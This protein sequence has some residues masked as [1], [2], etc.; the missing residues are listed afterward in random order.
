M[1][2]TVKLTQWGNSVGVRLP[3]TMLQSLGLETGQQMEIEARDGE[4][5]LRPRQRPALDALLAQ[6]DFTQAADTEDSE[7]FDD[8]PTG[9]EYI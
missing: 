2:T 8:A 3:K 7:W 5:T 6:C 1:T 9:E 4:I